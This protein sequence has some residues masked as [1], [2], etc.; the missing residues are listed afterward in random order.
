MYSHLNKNEENKHKSISSDPVQKQGENDYTDFVDNSPEAK[1][2]VQLQAMADNSPEAKQAAQL[3]AMADSSPE[4]KEA[5]RLQAMA[6][7][8][9]EVEQPI[10]PN[11]PNNTGLPDDLKTGIENL[12]GYSM[13][14][15][16][17][18]YNSDKPAQLQAH[19]Y[20]QGTDIY[21]G[22]GQ[23][24]HL[25]HEAW[26]VVQQMQG[27]VKPTV[28]TENGVGVNDDKGLET[29]ADAMGKEIFNKKKNQNQLAHEPIKV[30]KSSKSVI[31]L[32]NADEKLKEKNYKI[33]VVGE[34]HKEDTLKKWEKEYW[35]ENGIDIKYEND[36]FDLTY[37][38]KE[39]S[40]F[41]DDPLLR[42]LQSTEFIVNLFAKFLKEEILE[43]S[44]F[45]EEYDY[46]KGAF[47]KSLGKM[48]DQ[49]YTLSELGKQI[50]PVDLLDLF[51]VIESN[52]E[53]I[54]NTLREKKSLAIFNK[55][56]DINQERED[57][58]KRSRFEKLQDYLS[59]TT[60][61]KLKTIN[62]FKTINK[63]VIELEFLTEIGKKLL[64]YNTKNKEVSTIRTIAMFDY[65]HLAEHIGAENTIWKIG[66]SHREELDSIE[67]KYIPKSIIIINRNDYFKD[68]CVPLRRK[69][70]DVNNISEGEKKL[71]WAGF[72]LNPQNRKLEDSDYN[73]LSNLFFR[74]KEEVSD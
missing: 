39:L 21:L 29:E 41:F 54:D 55:I 57:K 22:S 2:A 19:A 35:E 38:E 45:W 34:M 64:S 28:T 63:S 74:K 12:S 40:L 37:E 31:Q 4:A 5:A 59:S 67:S 25:P 65:L 18:H 10:A 60:E 15:V 51:S 23:E 32:K 8:N 7:K 56:N 58:E 70:A 46:L 20:A 16:K 47:K 66:D 42:V 44:A 11:K 26:H 48:N 52:M 50:Y 1:Q 71:K 43:E 27:R 69:K 17:V 49:I 14:D 72:T 3:Q 36:S 9:S 53:L 62:R 61:K 33:A 24:K 6:D 68:V 73:S 13:D 30:D